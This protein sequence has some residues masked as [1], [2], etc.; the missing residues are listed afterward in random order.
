MAGKKT[1]WSS[2]NLLEPATEGSR[3]CQFSVSSKKVKLTGDLRV[4][5]GDDP[6]A[7]AVGKDWS[8]LLSR[9]LNIAT[10]PPEKVFLRVV[11]LPECEPDEL[12]P[13]VEFQIEELSPL[14]M[15]QTVWSAEAVP[16]SAGAEGNQTV[17]V[18][19]A[20]RGVVE[21]RLDE[22]EAVNYLADRVEVP[23]LR[24]LVPGEP[25]EDGAHIQ[26][27]QGA[28][29]VLALVSWWFDGRLRDVNSFNLPD[30]AA[31]R[32]ALVEKINSIALAGEVAGWMPDEPACH[33]TKRGD[34]AG[35]WNAA[36]AK[37]FGRIREVEPMSEVDLATAAVE[38]AARTTAP[39]LML[40]DYSARNRQRFQDGLWMQ[41]IKGAVALMLIG[42]LGFYVY[43]SMLKGTLDEKQELVTVRSN[44]YN[45]ALLL[46][47]KVETLEKQK[48]L[49]YAALEAWH[50][51]STGLPGELKFTEL[52]FASGRTLDGNT[53][54]ELRISGAADAGKATLIDDYQ[55]AL[56]RMER[57]D[58]KA[59]FSSVRAETIR[60]DTRKN[61][62]VWSLK[63][64][65]DGE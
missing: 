5:E 23:L 15:A 14:P 31:S 1:K 56:T 47:A 9:K 64:E 36:L 55:E 35:D 12:L 43:G 40:E 11:E 53:S 33:L 6:P 39:G 61:Q 10:L 19:I 34:V 30:T 17:L 51:V 25:R 49:K 54:R 28:D 24:E 42:L 45:G 44:Q 60:Q 27:V 2:C 59:L 52:A 22:L 57:S 37:C 48:A 4:A 20:E 18:M 26:L 58:G 62:T 38:F 3:L 46:K 32:D 7:K 41:G 8:D 65:F 63:C 13:M 50:K 16:G 21:D 29:S